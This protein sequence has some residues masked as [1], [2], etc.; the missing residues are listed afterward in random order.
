M[1]WRMVGRRGRY[2]SWTIVGDPVQTSWAVP[3][4]AAAARDEA[5]GGRTR[6][7]FL[8]RTN[9]R[10][11][12]EIFALAARVIGSLAGPERLPVAVRATGVEPVVSVVD[13]GELAAAVVRGVRVLL[14]E[15]DGTVGVITVMDRVGEF[16]RVL[17]AVDDPRLKV[18]G[19]LDS[20]GLEY[21]ATLV[22][23]PADLIGESP[24]G[25]RTL[26]VAMT[27]ATQ[28][29]TILTTTPDWY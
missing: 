9:Y 29:M 3:E 26:Y 4:E 18:V 7:H 28:R 22:V 13:P 24:N 15:V 14:D 21:D 8:L 6:R 20:K 16:R 12:A 5:L 11:S 1:Q 17:S 19:S 27:R 25:R 23:E 2:A 10:N